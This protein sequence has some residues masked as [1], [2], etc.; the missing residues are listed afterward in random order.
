MHEHICPVWVGYLLASPIRRLIHNPERILEPYI[1]P[2][3]TV[4]DVG[5]AMGYFSLPM[6]RMAGASG[7]VLCADCQAGMFTRLARRARRAG[8]LERLTMILG[9]RESLCLAGHEGSVD[10][11]LAMAMVHEVPDQARL[12]SEVY[13][14]LKAGARFLVAEPSGH[15]REKAFAESL[16]HA[17][18]AGFQPVEQPVIARSRA[19]LLVKAG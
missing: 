19:V 1:Q 15:V 16:R 18:E 12:F 4:L 14:A 6:A 13:A 3:M 5:C 8:V 10:F 11:A 17:Q 9:T 2:G 7:R